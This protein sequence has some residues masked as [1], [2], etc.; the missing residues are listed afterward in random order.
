MRLVDETHRADLTCWVA[1]AA[2]RDTDF[3]IQNLPYGVFRTKRGGP[4]RVG[5]AIGETAVDLAILEH[6]RL[7]DATVPGSTTSET[8]FD[9]PSLNAFMSRGRPLWNKI[10][11]QLSRLLRHDEPRLRDDAGT[12]ESIPT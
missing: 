12:L 7:I 1:S 3:P 4:A 5:A 11:G 2:A 10:R 9:R 8:L 6:E